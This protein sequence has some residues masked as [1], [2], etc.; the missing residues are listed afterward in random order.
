M[1][2]RNAIC[3]G[4]GACC[5]DIQIDFDKDDNNGQRIIIKNACKMGHAKFLQAASNKRIREPLLKDDKDKTT[6]RKAS[7]EQALEKASRILVDAKRPLIFLGGD[8]TCEAMRV[9]LLL[10]ER[11]GGVV[12]SITSVSDGPAAMGIQEA[13]LVGATAGQ[14]KIR[15]D[16]AIYWG[17]NPLES[18]PRHMSLYAIY[19]RGYWTNGGW[20]DRT[21][22]TV[23]PRRSITAEMSNI[24]I[25]LNAG[26]DYE[27]LSAMLS[28]LHGIKPHPSV[29]KITG[30]A[31]DEMKDILN[32][33]KRC[34]YGVIYLGSG[35]TSSPGKH[36]NVEL[37]LHLTAELNRFAKFIASSMRSNCNTCGFNHTAS[38]LYGFPFGIDFSRGYPRYNPGEFTTVNLLRERDIDAALLISSNL[39][40]HLPAACAE[41]LAEIPTV[42][43]DAIPGPMTCLA[44]VVLPGSIDIIESEGTLHRFDGVSIYSKPILSSPF[45]FADGNENILKQLF[46]KVSAIDRDHLTASS[47][48]IT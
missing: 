48:S 11:L 42:C 7:W 18:M 27:L 14:S 1:T 25:Q 29:E 36:R 17:A 37:A 40:A 8:L 4:C 2:I 21:I 13:G 28:L 39:D 16:L 30:I 19:P 20:S 6:W 44:D 46:D 26:T 43:I 12:D 41:Y 15:S 35:I 24:H 32:M 47:I 23:D 31:V 22:I 3:P 38:S 9:G 34:N 5:D 45:S 33:M 10:G